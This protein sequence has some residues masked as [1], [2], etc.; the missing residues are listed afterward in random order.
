[1]E[2]TNGEMVTN[3][4]SHSSAR[5]LILRPSTRSEGRNVV[6]RAK[7]RDSE[8]LAQRLQMRLAE[9]GH[10]HRNAG[11]GFDQKQARN[12][13]DPVEITRGIRSRIEQGWQRN[14]EMAAELV[15]ARL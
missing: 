3:L 10:G 9:P 12:V 7:H 1:M 4:Y 14:L 11:V 2:L 8:P 13:A 6:V 15:R 5:E